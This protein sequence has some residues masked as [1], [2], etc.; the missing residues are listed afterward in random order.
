MLLGSVREE[1]MC[2]A[3]R[4][5]ASTSSCVNAASRE[6][7]TVY[8]SASES[9]C[10]VKSGRSVT[11]TAPSAGAMSCTLPGTERT[12]RKRRTADQGPVPA[13]FDARARQ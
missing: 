2:A 12:V 13:E 11:F 3:F 5:F 7:C 9:A 6:T 10:Q 8:S 1:I 4:C